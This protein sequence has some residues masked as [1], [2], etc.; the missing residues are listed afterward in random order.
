[1]SNRCNRLNKRC[2]FTLETPRDT[3]SPITPR[4]GPL[5]EK[6]DQLVSLLQNQ[7]NSR[8]NETQSPPQH[9]SRTAAPIG[10]RE[11]HTPT[12]DSL[13]PQSVPGSLASC[14]GEPSPLQADEYLAIF[15]THML[16]FFPAFR[17]EPDIV[18]Q[19]L[20]QEKPFLWLCIM[21]VACTSTSHQL[22]LGDSI[23]QIVAREIVYKSQKN[24]DFL[25]GLLVF[26]AWLV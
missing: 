14:L 19:Q 17:L 4:A 22:L 8:L 12:H 23:K 26:I 13:Y 3:G 2:V 21:C 15:R 16:R 18:S 9:N 7:Q 1:M 25:L 10:P 6:L 20:K 5:E 24:M 11:D